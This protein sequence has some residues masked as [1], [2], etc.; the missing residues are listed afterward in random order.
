MESAINGSAGGTGNRVVIIQS[1]YI[2]WKG[3]FDL[4]AH[5]DTV[6]LFDSVQS[7]KNDWRNRNMIKAPGGKAWLT[8]PVQHSN[9]LRIREVKVAMR[10][11]H[12]KHLRTIRQAYARAPFAAELFPEL[13][14]WYGLAGECDTLSAVNRVFL[15]A[16]CQRLGIQCRFVEV[17]DVL[18]DAEHDRLEPTER[19]VEIC[20][21]IQATGYL[22]GPAA[23]DYLDTGAFEAA[24]VGVEWFDYEGY[25]EYPQLHGP[26]DG[27]V[28]ILD[29]LLMNGPDSARV[30][31]RRGGIDG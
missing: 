22:S 15:F 17:H 27:A 21:R 9:R 29:V 30:A 3:Y 20:R 6:V 11:W 28:S 23:R 1:N 18:D 16:I 24:G 25:P 5:A 8:I 19:L 10:G 26:F 4:L 7:T 14:R 31:L 12:L 13:E 2:P